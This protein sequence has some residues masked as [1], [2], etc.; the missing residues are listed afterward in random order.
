[1][2]TAPQSKKAANTPWIGT[3][4]TSRQRSTKQQELSERMERMH[5]KR[6]QEADLRASNRRGAALEPVVPP[7]VKRTEA[8]R[9]PDHRYVPTGEV[10]STFG[11]IGSYSDDGSRWARAV[12]GSLK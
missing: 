6:S 10:P 11:P 3:Y 7:H 1:M 4:K 9:P 2:A 5:H 12:A 8:P